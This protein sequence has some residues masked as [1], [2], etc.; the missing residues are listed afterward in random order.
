MLTTDKT[1]HNIVHIIQNIVFLS[2]LYG[3]R[4]M[5]DEMKYNTINQET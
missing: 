3:Y 2:Y 5:Y 1:T 4:R